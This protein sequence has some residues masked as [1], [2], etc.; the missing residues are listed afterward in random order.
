MPPAPGAVHASCIKAPPAPPAPAPARC[1]RNGCGRSG[2]RGCGADRVAHRAARGGFR[3]FHYGRRRMVSCR[4]AP[5]SALSFVPGVTVASCLRIESSLRASESSVARN[6]VSASRCRLSRRVSLRVARPRPAQRGQGGA[7]GEVFQ[8]VHQE[9]AIAG[10][11][12]FHRAAARI[13]RIEPRAV[14]Q[15]IAIGDDDHGGGLVDSC[16]WGAV[17]FT[18]SGGPFGNAVAKLPT[19]RAASV[20]LASPGW[21]LR[22]IPADR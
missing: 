9:I 6:S 11:G 20:K 13:A 21:Y 8:R 4:S 15:H 18:L 2:G 19:S 14:G 17:I 7:A 10:I 1:S 5:S 22:V 3:P 16:S 12:N